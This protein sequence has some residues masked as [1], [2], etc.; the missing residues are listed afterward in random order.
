MMAQVRFNRDDFHGEI[1]FYIETPFDGGY[2]TELTFSEFDD[3]NYYL[4]NYYAKNYKELFEESDVQ[5]VEL[6]GISFKGR[7]YGQS[8]SFSI[9]LDEGWKQATVNFDEKKYGDI[10]INKLKRIK[11]IINE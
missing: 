1:Q 9:H 7:K 4:K 10:N 5:H 11:G 2:Q 6:T 3:F 8:E